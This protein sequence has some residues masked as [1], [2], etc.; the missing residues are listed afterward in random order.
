MIY[1]IR[2]EEVISAQQEFWQE[3]RN[4]VNQILNVNNFHPGSEFSVSL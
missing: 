4:S 2:R 3:E 1:T